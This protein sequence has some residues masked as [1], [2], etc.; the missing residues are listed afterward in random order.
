M[1]VKSSKTERDQDAARQR[2]RYVDQAT[3]QGSDEWR[4]DE[5]L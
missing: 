4:H 5:L 3:E 1:F 2:G